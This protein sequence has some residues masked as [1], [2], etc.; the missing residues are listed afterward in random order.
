MRKKS[1]LI[2]CGI[3]LFFAVP[4]FSFAQIREGNYLTSL[5]NQQG[6][7]ELFANVDELKKTQRFSVLA[8]VQAI[9]PVSKRSI[10]ERADK[11]LAKPWPLLTLS[12]FNEFK[13]TGNRSG[14][15][16]NY[17]AR[18]SKLTHLVIGEV[19]ER[20]GR[21][22]SEIVDGLGLVLEESSWA[23]P[24]HM[25]LQKAGDGLPDIEEPVIDLF[26]AQ[27]AMV[28]AWTRFLLADEL[29]S[30]SPQ[31][32]ARM[33]RELANRVFNPYLQRDDFWWMGFNKKRMNNWNIYVNTNVLIAA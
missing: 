30:Y 11:E 2:L 25:Y 1:S 26:V 9:S 31:L 16:G 22:L 33:D 29:D 7:A 3:A 21:Y 12:Q 28:L 20:K 17:F 32:L 19:V 6:G 10:I 4:L 8:N 13:L 14:Y 15:E 24:A 23:L 27:T 18:R 5:F